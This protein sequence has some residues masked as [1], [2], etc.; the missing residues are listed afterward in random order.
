LHPVV[1]VDFA[2]PSLDISLV[3]TVVLFPFVRR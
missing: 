2:L 3:D 1:Q